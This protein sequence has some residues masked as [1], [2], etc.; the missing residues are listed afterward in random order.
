LLFHPVL[1]KYEISRL[2]ISEKAEDEEGKVVPERGGK[3]N[4][5]RKRR[6]G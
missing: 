2:E 1:A 3:K 4:S 5:E 6:R